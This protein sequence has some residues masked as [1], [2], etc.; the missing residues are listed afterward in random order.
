MKTYLTAVLIGLFVMVLPAF[1]D[2][3]DTYSKDMQ[4]KAKEHHQ[5]QRQENKAFRKDMHKARVEHAKEKL[6]DKNLTEAEKA[7]LKNFKEEQKAKREEFRDANKKKKEDFKNSVIK[8]P[9]LSK[10]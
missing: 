10:D 4:E 7:D 5:M 8:N 2:D 1:A 9:D 6:K 3:T